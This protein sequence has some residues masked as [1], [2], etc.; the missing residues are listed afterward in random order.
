MTALD[1]IRWFG[2]L[3]AGDVASVGG[4]TASLGELHSVL[5]QDGVKVP[6]GFAITAQAYRDALAAA[7][8]WTPLHQLLDGLDKSDVDLLAERAAAARKVVYEATGGSALRRHWWRGAPP[9]DYDRLPGSEQEVRG[10]VVRRRP[11]LGDG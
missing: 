8:A 3:G 7:G 6:E 10:R 9:A 5:S 2:D 1:Y 11:Q 4:K